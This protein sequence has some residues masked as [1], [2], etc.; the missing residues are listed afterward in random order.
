MCG[1]KLYETK[2]EA[3]ESQKL[4]KTSW[5]SKHFVAQLLYY[6]LLIPKF[7]FWSALLI[8]EQ[9]WGKIGIMSS[10]IFLVQQ[11]VAFL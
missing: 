10:A 1:L 8:I 11:Q 3:K 7:S 9:F 5:L 2:K 4:R 6:A